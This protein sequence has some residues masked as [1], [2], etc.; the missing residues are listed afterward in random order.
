MP[1]MPGERRADRLALDRGADLADPRLGLPLLGGRAIELGARDHALV[2][3]PLHPVEVEPRQ[4]ALRLD[5]RE[6]RPLLPRVEHA[7]A[8]RPARTACPESNAIRSTVPG[9]SALTVTPCTA[10][11]V[12]IALSV[13]GHVSC[14]ATMVVTASGG[15]WNAAPCAIAVWICWNFTNP[16][17]RD[18][19]QR[20]GQHHESFVSP[21]VLSTS[22]RS[23]FQV[24][25]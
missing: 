21:C 1:R 12:P 14:C 2:Q 11:I 4:L 15:G 16:R 18:E 17:R 20:H 5:R 13:A 25:E 22:C 24:V 19:Q 23:D 9:R 6:L 3:Q 8:R 10:A 7:P